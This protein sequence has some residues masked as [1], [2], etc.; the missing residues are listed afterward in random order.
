MT[1]ACDNL[2]RTSGEIPI[3]SRLHELQIVEMAQEGPLNDGS[4]QSISRMWVG[5]NLGR[6][7]GGKQSS[8][9]D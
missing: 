8:I 7:S 9:K 2:G 3:R 5:R 6:S 4:W 1:L